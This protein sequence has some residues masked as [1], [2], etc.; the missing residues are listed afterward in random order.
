MLKA[1]D[2]YSTSNILCINVITVTCPNPW[3]F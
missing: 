2:L 1:A 3:L